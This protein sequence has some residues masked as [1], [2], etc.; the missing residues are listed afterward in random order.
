MTSLPEL[1]RRARDTAD[2]Q[3]LVSAIPY[4]NFMGLTASLE[5]GGGVVGE[6]AASD[7]L[8]GNARMG[9]LHG[10]ATAAL[11]ESTAIFQLLFSVDTGAVPKTINI[12][13]QYLRSGKH[14]TTRARAEITRLGRRVAN[15]YSTA[16]QDDRQRPIAAATAH[17]LLSSPA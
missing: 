5:A 17:F 7:H 3:P 10:G 2:P 11:L 12:T 8:I 15:V 13:L 16:W 14:Q 4:A 1:I 9:H 6:L